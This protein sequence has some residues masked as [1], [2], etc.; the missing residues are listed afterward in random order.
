MGFTTS[1][2]AC[3]KTSTTHKP[4]ARLGPCSLLISTPH[5]CL[6]QQVCSACLMPNLQPCPAPDFGLPGEPACQPALLR[7]RCSAA[8]SPCAACL[9]PHAVAA[10]CSAP[11][12]SCHHHPHPKV[13]HLSHQTLAAT[14]TTILTPRMAGARFVDEQTGKESSEIRT[15]HSAAGACRAPCF[16]LHGLRRGA[17]CASVPAAPELV[18][19]AQQ[20]VLLGRQAQPKALAQRRQRL[21]VP[22]LCQ[23][24]QNLHAAPHS[25]CVDS[26]ESQAGIACCC[27]AAACECAGAAGDVPPGEVAGRIARYPGNGRPA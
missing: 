23:L 22:L 21:P 7:P 15:S 14:T 16:D 6:L 11:V 17:C 19:G 2:Q 12:R 27:W 3:L 20:A 4:T 1:S 26:Q 9:M 8:R 24:C 10:D 25:C 13:P 5:H 18:V